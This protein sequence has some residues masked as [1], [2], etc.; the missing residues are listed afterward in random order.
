MLLNFIRPIGNS[1]HKTYDPLGTKL[2]TRLRLG[3]SHLSEH[4][5]RHNFTDSLNPLCF[6]SL[7]STLHFFL[8]YQNYTTLHRALMTDLKNINDA[9][10]SL[11]ESDLLH[12]MLYGSKKFDNNMNMSILTA[13]I[14][15]SKTLEGL[16]NLFFKYY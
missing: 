5:F 7:E 9:T 12:V 3:F 2:L 1:T 14:K 16:I 13:T 10:M 4:K 15:L 6:C 11:N 8:R